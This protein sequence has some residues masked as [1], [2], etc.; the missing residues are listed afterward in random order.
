MGLLEKKKPAKQTSRVKPDAIANWMVDVTRTKTD[1]I[2][3]NELNKNLK[4]L[5]QSSPTNWRNSRSNKAP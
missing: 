2:I 5:K 1:K 4:A 3:T